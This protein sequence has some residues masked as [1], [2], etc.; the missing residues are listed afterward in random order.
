MKAFVLLNLV[1][2]AQDD[3]PDDTVTVHSSFDQLD[4]AI[5]A[6]KRLATPVRTYGIAQLI[7]VVHTEARVIVE[8]VREPVKVAERNGNGAPKPDVAALEH[9]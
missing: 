2:G 7:R 9:G 5:E 4:Q 8:E 6:A 1:S 3:D